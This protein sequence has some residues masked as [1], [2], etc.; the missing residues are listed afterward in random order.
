[1]REIL[2]DQIEQDRCDICLEHKPLF[3]IDGDSLFLVCLE[4]SYVVKVTA[5]IRSCY[6][7]DTIEW[8]IQTRRNI[9][10]MN[11]SNSNQV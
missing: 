10:S 9:R 1:M 11:E 4:C 6:I 8:I 3:S 5:R 7:S 2:Q